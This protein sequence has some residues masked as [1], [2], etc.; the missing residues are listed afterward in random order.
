[1]CN[2][3]KVSVRI[4]GRAKLANTW[5]VTMK[6]ICIDCKHQSEEYHKYVPFIIGKEIKA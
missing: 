3:N 4:T 1:M 2:H 5:F 6:D